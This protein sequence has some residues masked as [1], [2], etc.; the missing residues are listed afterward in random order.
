MSEAMV[1]VP[2][3]GT[4]HALAAL[5]VARVMAGLLET[6]LHV[7][8]VAQPRNRLNEILGAIDLPNGEACN[9]IL[10]LP[11]GD[12][13]A[14]IL[15]LARDGRA[16]MIVMCSHTGM[17]KPRG[18]LG[19]VA[20]ELFLQAPCPVT[21]VQP[22]RGTRPW[23]LRVALLPHDGSPASAEAIAPALRLVERADAH[24]VLLHVRSVFDKP[25]AEPGAM[26][27]PKYID[28][29]QHEWP[30]WS[31]EF[32]ERI[33]SVHAAALDSKRMQVMLATG[34][35]GREVVRVANERHADLILVAWHGDL[36]AQ[37]AQTLKSMIAEA[38]CPLT[39]F[40][41]DRHKF[42]Q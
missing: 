36:S 38:P 15:K 2:L 3:D 35:A 42:F 9:M 13:G 33:R 18:Q 23:S 41:V 22:D 1:L 12:P 27:G 7:V 26:G 29:P 19:H 6:D 28:Q 32:M 5:P 37:R 14:E 4:P 16:S 20:E 34:T 31:W 40:R 11:E 21:L 24:L 30:Q 39:A 17:E 10:D 8:N 25:L